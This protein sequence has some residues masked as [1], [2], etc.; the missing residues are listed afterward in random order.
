MSDAQFN[1]MIRKMDETIETMKKEDAEMKAYCQLIR[2][3]WVP[4]N[5]KAILG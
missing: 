5:V 2:G 1:Q 3:G 4:C